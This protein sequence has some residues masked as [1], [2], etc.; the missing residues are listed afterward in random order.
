MC[1]ADV[2]ERACLGRG[3]TAVALAGPAAEHR[4]AG[5]AEVWPG[6]NEGKEEE[7]AKEESWEEE[8]EMTQG[9]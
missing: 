7:E 8:E 3:S 2:S 6:W 9:T 5:E 1:C 4:A